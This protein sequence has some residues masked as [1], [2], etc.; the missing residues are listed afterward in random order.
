VKLKALVIDDSGITRKMVMRALEQVREA[1]WVFTEAGDGAEG[2]SKFDPQNTDIVFVDWNMPNMSGIDLV[3][4]LRALYPK[5]HVPIVMITTEKILAKAEEALR[6]GVDAFI[7]KPFTPEGLSQRMA[8][9]FALLE[10]PKP[11][12]GG[13]F[14]RLL[15]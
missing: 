4:K 10:E 15:S 6:G 2:L 12:T 11:E 8:K 7:S 1:D 13:F 14:K 3:R 5:R 9:V